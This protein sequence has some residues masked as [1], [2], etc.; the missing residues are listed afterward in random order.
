MGLGRVRKGKVEEGG[1][2][3]AAL[4]TIRGF[5]S[6]SKNNGSH[7]GCRAEEGHD[8]T[9]RLAPCFLAAC[10]EWTIEGMGAEKMD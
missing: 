2:G 9:S 10:G 5:V 7:G 1:E 3:H 4:E 8:M 6:D